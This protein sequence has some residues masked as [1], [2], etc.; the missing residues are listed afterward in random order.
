MTK[1][2]S[3]TTP[4]LL[5]LGKNSLFGVK[6]PSFGRGVYFSKTKWKGSKTI[7]EQKIIHANVQERKHT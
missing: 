1:N 4:N 7:K 5:G 2:T 6:L 3:P